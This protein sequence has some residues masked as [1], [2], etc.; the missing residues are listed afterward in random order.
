MSSLARISVLC[1]LL[2]T[3]IGCSSVR[4]EKIPD[5]ATYDL[6]ATCHADD[7]QAELQP[8]RNQI[9]RRADAI[10]GTRYYLPRPY[11]VVKKPFPVGGGTYYIEAELKD[12]QLVAVG[13]LDEAIQR[14]FPDG[15]L[16]SPASLKENR[17]ADNAQRGAAEAGS[18]SGDEG[19]D[20]SDQDPPP[21]ETDKEVKGAQASVSGDPSTDPVIELSPLFDIVLLPDFSEQYAIQVR[22]GLFRASADIGLEN[23]WMAEKI[24][25]D[26]DNSQLGELLTTTANKLVDASITSFFPA[27]VAVDKAAAQPNANPEAIRLSATESATA[28]SET[29]LIRV[30]HVELTVPGLYPILKPHELGCTAGAKKPCIPRIDWRTRSRIV[31]TLETSNAESAPISATPTRTNPVPLTREDPGC[32][33]EGIVEDPATYVSFSRIRRAFVDDHVRIDARV[34]QS[35]T[36]GRVFTLIIDPANLKKPEEL[37]NDPDYVVSFRFAIRRALEKCGVEVGSVRILVSRE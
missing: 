12:G 7:E 4:I 16:G 24:N 13:E 2:V 11:V 27:A 18:D 26:I 25:T 9:Q 8:C 10:E 14:Y 1:A 3:S 17:P 35:S 30:D 37:E 21:V 33:V 34:T 31:L 15:R 23:G 6:H 36:D 20:E 29:V 5:P 19:D 32:D 28:S 22:S